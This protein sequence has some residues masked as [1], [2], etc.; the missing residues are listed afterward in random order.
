MYQRLINP[1]RGYGLDEKVVCEYF[2]NVD[3]YLALE[4][5]NPKHANLRLV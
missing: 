2:S 3:L 5:N 4:G 1:T